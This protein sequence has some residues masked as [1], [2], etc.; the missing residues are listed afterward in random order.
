M[1]L[2]ATQQSILGWGG[3]LDY[4]RRRP[5]HGWGRRGRNFLIS[6]L[7]LDLNFQ[8]FSSF[9]IEGGKKEKRKKVFSQVQIDVKLSKMVKK[10]FYTWQKSWGGSSPQ[11]PPNSTSLST[12]HA[13][14]QESIIF[15]DRKNLLSWCFF[16]SVWQ[17]TF[18]LLCFVRQDPV[19]GVLCIF[20]Y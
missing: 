14:K 5:H 17:E 13:Q 12:E 7:I 10:K 1:I 19:S 6:K 2:A 9:G 11:A 20:L 3:S 8:T 4:Q 16:C 15:Y 18:F